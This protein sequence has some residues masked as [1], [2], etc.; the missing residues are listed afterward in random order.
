[1]PNP[2]VRDGDGGI[3]GQWDKTNGTMEVD[4]QPNMT[5]TSD[6][7]VFDHNGNYVGHIDNR[8]RMS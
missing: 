4:G 7:D 5:V 2:Y 1:M 3:V 8:G 6:G